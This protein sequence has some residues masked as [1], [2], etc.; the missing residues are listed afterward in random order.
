MRPHSGR[1]YFFGMDIAGLGGNVADIRPI[2]EY[3]RFIPMKGIHPRKE[4]LQTFGY[5]LQGSFITGWGGKTAPPFERF[6]QGGDTDLRG[7]DIRAAGPVALISDKQT[8]PLTNPDGSTVLAD[9]NNP[10][11]GAWPVTVPIT[12]LVYPGGDTS[13]VSNLE[14]RIPIVGPVTFAFFTDTGMNMAVRQSQL[15]LS[16]QQVSALDST[17]F[18][19]PTQPIVTFSPSTGETITCPDSESLK[20]SQNLTPAAHTNYVVRMSTG[21]ELQVILPVVNAPFRIYYAYNPLR[22]DTTAPAPSRIT[23]DMF[24]TGCT[25][26]TAGNNTYLNAIATYNPSYKILEPRKTFRFTVATTF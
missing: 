22:V 24:P 10:N 15:R 25:T 3:K 23:C 6:F 19:C 18:G 16:D 1:S 11:A 17:P 9:P 14:Y 12:R 5:R 7:F 8:V 2:A 13:L 4:G 20:F 26:G 21:V